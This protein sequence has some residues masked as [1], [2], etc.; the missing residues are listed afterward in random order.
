MKK[1][2][3]LDIELTRGDTLKFRVTFSGRQLPAGTIAV[4]TVK[5]KAADDEPALIEKRGE[6]TDNWYIVHLESEDT[7]RAKPRL[8]Y[9][10]IRLLI[11]EGDGTCEVITPMNFATFML[12]EVVGDV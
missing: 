9:W 11:P 4:F 3:G 8:Y 12:T 2:D 6:V 5:T 1:I 10:D 7:E